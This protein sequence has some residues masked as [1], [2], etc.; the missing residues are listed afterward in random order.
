MKRIILILNLLTYQIYAKELF[1]DF[2]IG[3]SLFSNISEYE[4]SYSDSSKDV[5]SSEVGSTRTNIGIG[6]SYDL[7]NKMVFNQPLVLDH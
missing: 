7:S 2:T 3:A 5:H 6:Y 1:T 4:I